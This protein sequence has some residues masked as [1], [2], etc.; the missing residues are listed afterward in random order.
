MKVRVMQQ[1]GCACLFLP[2]AAMYRKGREYCIS[3]SSGHGVL[4]EAAIGTHELANKCG[5]INATHSRTAQQ[6]QSETR[7]TPLHSWGMDGISD[8]G[9]MPPNKHTAATALQREKA[10]MIASQ[11][12]SNRKKTPVKSL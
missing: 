10:A 2:A 11:A 5:E 9:L 8:H 3:G 7:R 4:T 6:V 12:I 1:C